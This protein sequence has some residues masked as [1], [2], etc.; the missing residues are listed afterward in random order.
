M[1]NKLRSCK[2]YDLSVRKTKGFFG[3]NLIVHRSGFFQWHGLK[4]IGSGLNEGYINVS[5]SS[6][7]V[8]KSNP[9]ERYVYC[10][11]EIIGKEEMTNMYKKSDL[12]GIVTKLCRYSNYNEVYDFLKNL[13]KIHDLMPER[14]TYGLSTKKALVF[15][16]ACEEINYFLAHQFASIIAEK[17]VVQRIKDDYA[18]SLSNYYA[19]LIEP[20][21]QSEYNEEIIGQVRYLVRNKILI[22]K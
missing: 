2:I 15:C 14:Q 8:E 18:L 13:D 21:E 6:F 7:L 16:T 5:M 1:D 11:E 4:T 3:A 19:S 17:K 20:F 22:Y 12:Y 10:V 9:L